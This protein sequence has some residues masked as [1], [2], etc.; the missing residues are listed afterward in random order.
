M[1]PMKCQFHGSDP[2][3]ADVPLIGFGTGLTSKEHVKLRGVPVGKSTMVLKHIEERQARGLLA[4]ARADEY[5]I[6]K[7]CWVRGDPPASRSDSMIRAAN[8]THCTQRSY[9]IT[10]GAQWDATTSQPLIWHASGA[11]WRCRVARTPHL[12]LPRPPWTRSRE[13]HPLDNAGVVGG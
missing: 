9:A 1:G 6:S 10:G 3:V 12:R 8:H 13:R 4:A 7:T 11:I 2:T 5:K